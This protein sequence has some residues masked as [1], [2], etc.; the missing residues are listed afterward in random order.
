M[1]KED[2]VKRTRTRSW[3]LAGLLVAILTA[4]PAAAD[5]WA[6]VQLQASINFVDLVLPIFG[7]LGDIDSAVRPQ[8]GAG[9]RQL[10][11]SA[12]GLKPW[13]AYVGLSFDVSASTLVK[14]VELQGGVTYEL[15]GEDGGLNQVAFIG[16]GKWIGQASLTVTEEGIETTER[17][18]GLDSKLKIK[19]GVALESDPL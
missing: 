13:G 11:D 7:E 14:W 10:D 9:W 4:T 1:M 2:I 19:I 17:L 18:P 6:Q 5:D 12:D 16:L 15:V 8:F 3:G